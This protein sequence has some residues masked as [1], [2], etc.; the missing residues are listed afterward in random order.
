M[1]EKIEFKDAEMYDSCFFKSRDKINEIIDYIN[2]QEKYKETKKYTKEEADKLIEQWKKTDYH[3]SDL[4]AV[5]LAKIIAN[6]ESGAEELK[7]KNFYTS[8]EEVVKVI[9]EIIKEKS[10]YKTLNTNEQIRV[11]L[12]EKGKTVFKEYI[13]HVYE[14]LPQFS[15]NDFVQD[16][17]KNAGHERDSGFY[18]FR[19][20]EL[21]Q[22]F[23]KEM[24][25]GNF[26]TCFE[27]NII[28][29][30]EGDLK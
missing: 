5:E 20:H 1:I 27:G 24:Y 28:Y 7:R 29:I 4:R 19:L 17:L 3:S 8:P 9:K 13:E 6:T 22:I 23:G 21:M 12:T 11:K 2:K 14:S 25:V 10:E 16:Y 18:E 26:D 15:K 30:K